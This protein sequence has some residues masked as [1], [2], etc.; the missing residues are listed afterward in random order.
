MQ[1]ALFQEALKQTQKTWQRYSAA[2]CILSLSFLIDGLSNFS[3]LK[4]HQPIEVGGFKV[5]R[6]ALSATYGILFFVFIVTAY[7]ESQVLKQCSQTV[8]D[9]GAASLPDL[10]QL[11]LW[12][13]SPFSKSTM[14]RR[15]FW[16]MLIL[17][18]L[19]LALF[20]VIHHA[21]LMLPDPGRMSQAVY[22]SIGVGDLLLLVLCVRFCYWI[23]KNL[24]S[25]RGYLDD[26]KHCTESE[27]QPKIC[28][29]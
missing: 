13:V 15:L 21:S 14:L 12:F 5:V 4:G 20:T 25:V 16:G 19:F 9:T 8:A 23:Y 27:P 18:L 3:F 10:S 11:D 28:V 29:G 17:G 7:L 26:H 24:Q 22:V 2:I 1:T 6:E